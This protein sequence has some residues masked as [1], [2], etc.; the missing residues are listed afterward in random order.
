MDKEKKSSTLKPNSSAALNFVLNKERGSD[1]RPDDS[2]RRGKGTLTPNAIPT[3]TEK[4]RARE[5]SKKNKSD[6]ISQKSVPTHFSTRL[7]PSLQLKLKDA[8]HSRR[9]IGQKPFTLQSIVEEAISSWLA[10]NYVE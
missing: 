6:E 10:K 1:L 9:R 2:A 4:S 3:P 5:Q 7:T 8:C